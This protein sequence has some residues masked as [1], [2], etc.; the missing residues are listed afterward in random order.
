[1]HVVEHYGG[2]SGNYCV[3]SKKHCKLRSNNIYINQ[4]TLLNFN[5]F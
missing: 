2:A 4:L 5:L 1:M 3:G